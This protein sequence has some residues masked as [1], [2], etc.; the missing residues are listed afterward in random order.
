MKIVIALL[1]PFLLFGCARE[2]P[3]EVYV[4]VTVN[5]PKINVPP[6]PLLPIA[7]LTS[8]SSPDVVI[9]SYAASVKILEGYC[10]QLISIID[11]E[12]E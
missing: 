7:K 9:K 2:L 3:K 1:I 4:P 12:N 10:I 5:P 11:A 8:K 6:K